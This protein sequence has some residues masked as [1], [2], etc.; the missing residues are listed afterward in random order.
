MQFEAEGEAV[1]EVGSRAAVVDSDE[2]PVAIIET[3]QV[4]VL[5]AGDVDVRFALDEGEGLLSVAEWREAHERFWTS[6]PMREL[7]GEELEITD[8]MLVVAER[9]RVVARL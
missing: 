3:T 7:L 6:A 8:D 1:P 9:F 5:R 4:R 2:R